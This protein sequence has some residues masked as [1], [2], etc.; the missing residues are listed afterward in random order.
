VLRHI[1]G[2]HNGSGAT[3]ALIWATDEGFYSATFNTNT[4][5][6]LQDG[7]IFHETAADS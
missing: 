6:F 4:S 3:G 2:C 1:N 5:G 7:A